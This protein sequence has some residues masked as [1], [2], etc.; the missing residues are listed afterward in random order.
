M[1]IDYHGSKLQLT[2]DGPMELGEEHG[3]GPMVSLRKFGQSV[4]RKA[5]FFIEASQRAEELPTRKS[6]PPKRVW[7]ENPQRRGSKRNS[8]VNDPEAAGKR[9]SIL[10]YQDSP[11]ESSEN[12][13]LQIEATF[14]DERSSRD[15]ADDKLGSVDSTTRTAGSDFQRRSREVEASI[16]KS[17]SM[18]LQ[19][20]PTPP[21]IRKVSSQFIRSL[22]RQSPVEQQNDLQSSSIPKSE[23]SEFKPFHHF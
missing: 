17:T 15:G 1:Q 10:V 14:D 20:Q 18:Q 4:K 13:R 8:K 12:D 16:R 6:P 19:T 21:V 7:G 9:H 23:A 3:N 11:Q 22:L 2:S 5:S